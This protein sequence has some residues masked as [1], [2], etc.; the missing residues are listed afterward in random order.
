MDWEPAHADHSIDRAVVTLNWHQPID[1]NTF[2]ELVVAGHKAAVAHHLTNRAVLQDALELP[3]GG[4]MMVFGSNFTPPRRVAFQRLD[5][6]ST[7]V[8]EFSIGVHRIA[9]FTQRYRRWENLRQTI[10]EIMGSLEQVSSI[11]QNVKVARL[12]YLDR[13]QSKQGGAD[14]FEVIKKTLTTLHRGFERKARRFTFIPGG[15]TTTRRSADS[16]TLIS[17]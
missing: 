11:M 10:A 1:A 8:E 16:R 12:E 7:V 4:G 13:F 3:P 5:Q 6:T 17:M 15:L 2:D 14:H 9:Y